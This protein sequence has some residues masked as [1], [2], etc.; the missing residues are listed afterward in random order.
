MVK[1]DEGYQKVANKKDLQ[2]NHLLRVEPNDKPI[3]LSLVNGRVYAM[4]AVCSHEGGPLEEGTLEGYN[5]TCPWHYAIFDERNAKVSDQTVWATD[6]NS[7]AVKVD[8]DSGDIF[9]NPNA[10]TVDK[11]ISKNV[12]YNACTLVLSLLKPN[13]FVIPQPMQH[14]IALLMVNWY[15]YLLVLYSL[16]LNS[17]MFSAILTSTI[18]N[19]PNI[20]F[21]INCNTTL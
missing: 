13:R 4:D 2:Q 20:S 18:E 17:K 5:L 8:E 9:V 21:N 6:L 3:V 7:Y 10:S 12:T 16:N 14:R 1:E 11:A 19:S 15:C